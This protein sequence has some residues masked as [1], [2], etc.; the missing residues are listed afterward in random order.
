MPEV[1]IVAVLVGAVAAF[2]IGFVYYTMLG[3]RLAE[4]SEAAAAGEQ[5]PPW[6]IAVEFL[7]CL[8]LAA[9]VAGLAAQAGVDDWSGGLILGAVLWVGFPLVLWIGAVV[10]EKTPI[11]LAAIHAGDWLAKLLVLGLIAA[12][13]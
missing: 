5:M 7:R 12:T 1:S 13:L 11:Q 3:E 9:V 8:V 6:Q 4:V 10:H 2:I